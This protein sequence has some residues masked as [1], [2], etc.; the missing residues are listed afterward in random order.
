MEYLAADIAGRLVRR[1]MDLAEA[2]EE[3]IADY[4]GNILNALEVL[5]RACVYICVH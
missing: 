4:K 2:V 5:I 1:P 3:Q